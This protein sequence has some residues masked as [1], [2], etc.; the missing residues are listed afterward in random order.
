MLLTITTTHYPATDLG[1]LLHKHPDRMQSVPLSCGK[2]HIFYPKASE[3][4]CTVALLL[5]LDTVEMVRNR[6]GPAGDRLQLTHY[7]NDRPYVASSFMGTALSK[8]FSSAMNGTCNAKPELTTTDIPLEVEIAVLKST[9]G[10][11]LIRDLFEPLQYEVELK[12]HMLDEQFPTWGKSPYYTV[13]LKKKEKLKRVLSHLYVLLPVLDNDKHY[14]IDQSEKEKLIQKGKGWLD[15]HPLKEMITKRYLKHLQKYTS[16]LLET[17]ESFSQPVHEYRLEQIVNQLKTLGIQSVIDLGCGDG[18]LLELLIREKQFKRIAGMDISIRELEKAKRRLHYD[19]LPERVKDR[20]TLMAGA[21]NYRD[22]RTKGYEAAILSEVIE[23]I[24]ENRL[25]VLEENVFGFA[26]PQ[27]VIVTTPNAEYN[28]LFEESQGFRHQ[29]HRF[30]WNR[31][32]FK[33]WTKK[34]ALQFGYMVEV[35]PLGPEENPTFGTISQMAV[36]T[37]K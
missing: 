28:A 29:D 24:N 13:K 27:Y 10:E 12:E 3:Q 37:K 20:L 8:A 26:Q 36:F 2:A 5:E 1:Y 17:D 9:G 15:T 23:H 19:Q 4:K 34:V 25:P 14:W 31:M 18:K 21:L 30:E 32:Q 11:Q 35:F 33:E 6:K 16:D 7:V 22:E